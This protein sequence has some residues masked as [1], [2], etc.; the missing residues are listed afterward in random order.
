MGFLRI[1]LKCWIDG[2]LFG[3]GE[4]FWQCCLFLLELPSFSCWHRYNKRMEA[5][6]L[7]TG[8]YNAK[9][10]DKWEELDTKFI[11]YWPN[12]G[13]ITLPHYGSNRNFNKELVR[14]HA[15]T[16][17]YAGRHNKYHHPHHS[18]LIELAKS[19]QPFFWFNE[20]DSSTVYMFIT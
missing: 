14:K 17:T 18:V 8:D 1:P 16:I 11:D 3:L 4:T 7:Y 6:C 15:V 2:R 12:T 10:I 9:D 13:T 20:D 5:G 19:G